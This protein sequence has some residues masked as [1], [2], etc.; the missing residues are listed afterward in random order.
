M[1]LNLPS[2]TKPEL[3]LLFKLYMLSVS[4]GTRML[5]RVLS[6]PRVEI[7]AKSQCFTLSHLW[8]YINKKNAPFPTSS[9][10]GLL[11]IHETDVLRQPRLQQED[12]QSKAKLEYE[13]IGSTCEVFP[14]LEEITR[15]LIQVLRETSK[16]DL[17]YFTNYIHKFDDPDDLCNALLDYLSPK[18]RRL[19]GRPVTHGLL[20]N[21]RWSQKADGDIFDGVGGYLD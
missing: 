19:E 10:K 21:I 14:E 4:D 1:F 17:R 11:N 18:I 5:L 12:G 13:S 9:K 16:P 15:H 7:Q 20:E 2:L 6:T 8:Y 3:G